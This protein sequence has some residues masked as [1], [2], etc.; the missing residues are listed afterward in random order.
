MDQLPLGLQERVSFTLRALYSRYGYTQYKMNK[1]EEYDL[2]ARNKDFLVSDSVI[3]FTDTNGKL[4]ALKPDVTLSIVKNSRDLPQSVQKLYYHENV[5]RASRGT[6]SFQEIMQ[7]GLECLG[8]IDDYCVCEVLT[9]AAESL[10]AISPHCV[11]ELSHLGLLSQAIDRVGVPAREKAALL[12]CVGE[13]N[14]HE[15]TALCRRCGVDESGIAVLRSLVEISG[16]P[17]QVLPRLK[18]LL[19]GVAD[20]SPLEQ[21]SR[22]TGAMAPNLQALLRFD[23]S[24]VG[25]VNYYNGIVFKGFI[26]TLPGSVLSGGQYDNLMEKLGR[27][28]GAVGFAVYTDL[29]ER[30]EPAAGA[31]DVDAVLLYDAGADL[32]V[33]R[34]CVE[35]MTGRGMHVLAQRQVPENIRFRQLLRL[36]GSEVIPVEHNA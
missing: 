1:F 3:T 4:M 2:Y 16:Q 14:A 34:T 13:K 20:I 27:R 6:R 11:L 15:L 10:L 33:L 30:L 35:E 31:Y 21:L 25:D 24:V 36:C 8:E 7:I 17:Q 12:K 28:S 5:Y 19:A 22:V 9:L 29:L 23:F 26:H 32:T 18:Q